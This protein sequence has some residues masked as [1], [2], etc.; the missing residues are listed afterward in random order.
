MRRDRRYQEI[1]AVHSSNPP[2]PQTPLPSSSHS[3]SL[4]SGLGQALR[5][6]REKQSRK[7]YRVADTAGIT[8]GMLSAYET[9]RQRPSLETLDKLLETLGCDLNDLHN[10]LQ[11]VNGRPERIKSWR[12]WQTSA[13]ASW[14]E[15]GGSWPERPAALQPDRDLAASGYP[16]FADAPPPGERLT[17]AG[18]AGR[19]GLPDTRITRLGAEVREPVS[20]YGSRPGALPARGAAHPSADLYQV[21]GTDRPR[22]AVEEEQALGQMLDGFHGLLRYWHRS[23][24]AAAEGSATFPTLQSS[25]SAAPEADAGYMQSVAPGAEPQGAAPA[26]KASASAP[27]ADAESAGQAG[28]SATSAIADAPETGGKGKRR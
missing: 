24:T 14:P 16:R 19:T 13:W 10:A 25:R 21:L 23:L 9:G 28:G 4:L 20:P 2:S 26:A 11:I 7:Q 1:E 12:G 18:D 3:A 5:W 15:S 22:L 8:K 27:A 6:L 17:I